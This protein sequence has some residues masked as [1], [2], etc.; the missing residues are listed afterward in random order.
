M[1]EVLVAEC[2]ADGLL[3]D[4][5][6][7]TKKFSESA[8]EDCGPRGLTCG[9]GAVRERLVQTLLDEWLPGDTPAHVGVRCHAPIPF[10]ARPQ[11]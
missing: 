5:I 6:A 4:A 11:P 10:C 8:A 3:H 9:G 1:K 7:H 2:N